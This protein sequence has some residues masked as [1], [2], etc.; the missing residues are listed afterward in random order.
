MLGDDATL[1]RRGL[2][3]IAVLT[4]GGTAVELG[5]ERH[6]KSIEQGIAWL[7]VVTAAAAVLLVAVRVSRR[8]LIAAR[9]LAV[10]VLGLSLFGV[11]QHVSANYEA[12]ELDAVYGPRWPSLTES[13]R[14]RAALLKDVGPAPILAAGALAQ[15]G[16]LVL[17]ATLRHPALRAANRDE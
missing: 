7:V 11:V 8:G 9:V 3:A 2:I 4:V 10:L 16:L 14:W 6:W 17:L 1:F 15:A 5:L 12:G 13:A